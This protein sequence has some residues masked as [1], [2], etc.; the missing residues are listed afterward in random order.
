MLMVSRRFHSNPKI[1]ENKKS[2]LIDIRLIYIIFF[3]LLLFDVKRLVGI[4]TM[5]IIGPSTSVREGDIAV[6]ECVAYG[7]KPAAEIVWRNG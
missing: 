4:K 6:I 1:K 5:E 3:L 2:Q 7:S